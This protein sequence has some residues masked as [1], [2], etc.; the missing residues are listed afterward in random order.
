MK[1]YIATKFENKKRFDEV[2]NYLESIGHKL[3]YDWTTATQ[4]S[5]EQARLDYHGVK[6]ADFVVGI[7][8]EEHQ[9]KGAI[10]EIG[11]ALAWCK[12]VFIL[13]DWLDHMIFMKLHFVHK[14]YNI[15]QIIGPY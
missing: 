6:D 11:M 13:G 7:F 10:C 14:I 8:E 5:E 12:S 9:Y 3:T 15:E 1:F 4:Q 2:R